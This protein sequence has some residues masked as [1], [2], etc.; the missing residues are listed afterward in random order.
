MGILT[1][2]QEFKNKTFK[3]KFFLKV[4]VTETETFTAIIG[5]YPCLKMRK[6]T[7][8]YELIFRLF[9]PVFTTN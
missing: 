9:V 3:N 1:V 5:G 6:K 8:K 4:L 7:F 2:R